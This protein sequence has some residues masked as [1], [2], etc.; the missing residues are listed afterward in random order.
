MCVSIILIRWSPGIH[1]EISV[2]YATPICIKQQA[3]STQKAEARRKKLRP[4]QLNSKLSQPR[5]QM[6]GERELP[7]PRQLNGKMSQPA[8]KQAQ[9]ER[10]KLRPR[11][12]N[13]KLSQPRKHQSRP[14]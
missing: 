5:K 2:N 10:K 6:Q 13:G 12:L 7:R 14:N 8:K 1:S 4:T 3:E 11:Q 9:R